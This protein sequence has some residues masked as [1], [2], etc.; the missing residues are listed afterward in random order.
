[1]KKIVA[2]FILL[3]VFSCGRM[4]DKPKNLLPKEKMSAIIADFAIYD[5]AYSVNSNVN[6]ELAARFVLKKNKITAR[7]YNDSYKYYLS[8]PSD[9][10]EIYADAKE[11]LLKK[12]PKLQDYIDKKKKE[13]PNLP[14][15]VK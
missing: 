13:N 1:M 9:I 12:D 3:L 15:F 6:M 8:N 14:N 7:A 11:I 10:D 2:I 4:V 5:Q